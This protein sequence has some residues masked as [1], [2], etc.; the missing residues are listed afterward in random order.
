MPLGAH[1]PTLKRHLGPGVGAGNSGGQGHDEEEEDAANKELLARITTVR[2]WLV[3]LPSAHLAPWPKGVLFGSPLEFAHAWSDGVA[4]CDLLTAIE[5]VDR[6]GGGHARIAGVNRAPK[7]AASCRHNLN[8]A[9]DVLRQKR[10]INRA[11]LFDEVPSLPQSF[12]TCMLLLRRRTDTCLPELTRH[13][14]TLLQEAL[15]GAECNVALSLLEDIAAA[16]KLWPH[17]RSEGNREIN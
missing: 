12:P 17:K 7:S 8:K 4:F 3:K 6:A 13:V 9:L 14:P 11:H 10:G 15:L 5:G 1:I 16:Y 2:R